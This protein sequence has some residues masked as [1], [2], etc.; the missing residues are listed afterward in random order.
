MQ[1]ATTPKIIISEVP[2][3]VT[4]HGYV[5]IRQFKQEDYAFHDGLLAF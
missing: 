3:D 2:N 1:V 4:R 5:W